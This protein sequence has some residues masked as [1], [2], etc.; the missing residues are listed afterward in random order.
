M[1]MPTANTNFGKIDESTVDLKS[2]ALVVRA[3]SEPIFVHAQV[4]GKDSKIEIHGKALALVSMLDGKLV[5]VN[6]TDSCCASVTVT[7]PEG[8][9]FPHISVEMGQVLELYNDPQQPDTNL[10]ATKVLV[11]ERLSN[12]SCLLLSQ[13]HY[14]RL[15]KRF[16]LTQAL[17]KQEMDRVL[18]TA[19]AVSHLRP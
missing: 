9:K 3:G 19:A 11:N 13:A 17:P 8:S 14:V 16:Q 10:V 5:V 1:F 2:G 12:T 6:L 18:K 15:L 4:G 7:L